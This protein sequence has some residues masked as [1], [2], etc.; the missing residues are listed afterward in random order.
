MGKKKTIEY[1]KKLNWKKT[2]INSLSHRVNQ[3]PLEEPEL[4]IPYYEPY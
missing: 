1:T 4:N 2:F 3:V